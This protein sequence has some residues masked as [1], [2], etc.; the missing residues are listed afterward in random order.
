[1]SRPISSS[2]I[3]LIL[4][5][6]V[7]PGIIISCVSTQTAVDSKDLSYLYNP[8]RNPINPRYV[9]INQSDNQSLLSVKF[10]ASELYFSEANPQGIPT[11]QILITVKLY[12]ITKGRSLADT[13]YFNLNITREE[14]RLE[15]VYNIPL[16]VTPGTEYMTEIKILD[17]IRL[18]IIQAFVPFNTLSVSNR[19]NFIAQGHFLKNLLFN[20][21]VKTNE[22]LN[23]VY[24]RETIDSLFISYYKPFTEIP[25]PPSMLLPERI[26]DYDP[27]TTIALAYSDTLPLMFPEKGIYQC[28]TAREITEGYTICNFGESFP[29]LTTPEEMIEPLAYLASADEML[30]LRTSQKPKV[31]LDEFWIS[32]GGNIEK[33]RE[34][35]RIF[36]TRILYSNYYFS[37][38][39]EGWRTERGM[40]YTIYG[41]PDK[42]YKTSDGE[43]WGYRKPVIKTS[44]G[45]RYHL[46]E[47]YL[48]FNFRLRKSPFSDNEFYL[49]RSESL[50]T[51]WD[52]AVRSWRMGIVFRLDNPEGI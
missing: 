15:Y 6:S 3:R 18:K 29:N 4:L 39:R 20:P 26:L 46:K 50:V 32:C 24:R 37:T 38:Y 21:V 49:S 35:I 11:A 28:K 45:G 34:L 5:I 7:L 22:Y 9:I 31:A 27:D 2:I 16:R 52:Q 41:P 43:S 40:I 48:F 19:Y 14:S 51:F 42:V 30:N 10:F 1:M 23:L 44:W 13:A 17:R 47:N 36:Y 8:T 33:S 12:D 25:Q